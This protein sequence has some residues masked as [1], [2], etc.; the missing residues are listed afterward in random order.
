MRNCLQLH[1]KW[2]PERWKEQVKDARLPGPTVETLRCGT[3]ADGPLDDMITFDTLGAFTL[4][5]CCCCTLGCT[6]QPDNA[7]CAAAHAGAFLEW[8][9]GPVTWA[10][11]AMAM[12]GLPKVQ[13]GFQPG[14]EQW[15]HSQ[16][17][18]GCLY[19]Q[20]Q[21][22]ASLTG[23]CLQRRCPRSYAQAAAVVKYLEAAGFTHGDDPI[24]MQKRWDS[25]VACFGHARAIEAGEGALRTELRQLPLASELVKAVQRFVA[26]PGA[27]QWSQLREFVVLEVAKAISATGVVPAT[28]EMLRTLQR[29][30]RLLRVAALGRY[31]AR[32]AAFSTL[33]DKLFCF[34]YLLHAWGVKGLPLETVRDAFGVYGRRVMEGPPQAV[35]CQL[36]R[37]MLGVCKLA[38]EI[39]WDLT[40][41]IGDCAQQACAPNFVGRLKRGW[42]GEQRRLQQQQPQLDPCQ[43]AERS[44]ALLRLVKVQQGVPGSMLSASATTQHKLE[45]VLHVFQHCRGMLFR[46]VRGAPDLFLGPEAP[47]RSEEVSML[48]LWVL[49]GSGISEAQL[50]RVD[51]YCSFDVE[52]GNNPR[53]LAAVWL[54]MLLVLLRWGARVAAAEQGRAPLRAEQRIPSSDVLGGSVVNLHVTSD[55]MEEGVCAQL[56]QGAAQ[57][58]EAAA[59]VRT[60]TSRGP[61]VWVPACSMPAAHHRPVACSCQVLPRTLFNPLAV[62]VM[63]AGAARQQGVWRRCPARPV[64]HLPPPLQC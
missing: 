10:A 4:A 15:L 36:P 19:L 25:Y 29:A 34:L 22:L 6:H 16:C 64:Q 13:Q 44:R 8:M 57:V 49:E 20:E 23:N 63:R 9:N 41:F 26:V 38:A 18:A 61:G 2:L 28:L 48:L 30:M 1:C 43:V 59:L 12:P 5:G 51:P 42:G 45:W 46:A 47:G 37:D 33:L 54:W 60:Q 58:D 56:V 39:Q 21:G 40:A 50:M 27:E 7:H 24:V 55:F 52:G 3:S 31:Q 14:V 17:A 53:Q 11:C 62:P 32:R 35:P